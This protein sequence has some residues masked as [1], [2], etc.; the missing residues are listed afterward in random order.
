MLAISVTIAPWGG[1]PPFLGRYP[2]L[3]VNK[4]R[5]F[6]L[7]EL[8]V[9]LGILSLLAV[10]TTPSITQELN[11][12]RALVSIEESQQILDAARSYRSDKG[13]WPGNSTCSNALA[14]LSNVSDKY[15]AG[16][17]SF[18]RYGSPYSTSCT[19]KTFSLDQELVADWDSYLV[20]SIAGTEI[21]DSSTHLARSTIGIPGSEPA[22]DAKLSRV[23]T[24]NAELN[25]MRTTL[26]L[27]NNNVTEVNKLEAVT[28]QFSGSV[29]GV[30]LSVA[31]TAAIGGLLQAQ[32]ESQFIGK[33]AFDD[34]VILR[35]VAVAGTGGCTTGAIARDSTGKTLSCQSGIWTSNT[36]SLDGPYRVSGSSLGAWAMCTLNYGSGNSKSL[37][38]SNGSWFYSG[39]GTQVVYC[40]K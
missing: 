30:T 19:A 23:A 6:T 32:G 8:M 28:G 26:L 7:I 39:S 24:G 18:N 36:G 13:S 21:V 34:E 25:R 20:N 15:L 5:G 17:G 33:A 29:S 12:K 3:Q 1:Q 40:Y 16:V 14:V 37:T 22:L 9:V 4:I 2:R 10:L 31:Q 35:K 38:Y 27:G 11:H